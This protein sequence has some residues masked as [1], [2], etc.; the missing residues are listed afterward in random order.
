MSFGDLIEPTE[1]ADVAPEP[2]SAPADVPPEETQI[3]TADAV[4]AAVAPA[5]TGSESLVTEALERIETR[6]AESQRLIDRQS[7]IA[8]KLHAE[9][10]TLRRGELRTAQAALVLSVLRVYDDVNQMALTTE[11]PAA[12]KDLGIVAAALADALDR[13]GIAPSAAEPGEPFETRRH[14][15]VA[16]ETTDDPGADRT[17]ARVVRSGFDWPDGTVVRVSEVAVF[18]YTPPPETL[19]RGGGGLVLDGLAHPESSDTPPASKSADAP[20]AQ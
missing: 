19:E 2:A 10:Q 17:V 7:E 18:K 13:N 16:I 5:D 20:A 6:L 1:S 12:S 3:P 14:K 4:P 15:I 8:G 9:N 11:D